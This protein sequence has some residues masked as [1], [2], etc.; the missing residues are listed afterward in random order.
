MMQA[1]TSSGSTSLRKTLLK[2][3]SARR[4]D[5]L[6]L[7]LLT[8]AT[9]PDTASEESE[10]SGS[11]YTDGSESEYSDSERGGVF[12][13]GTSSSTGKGDEDEATV[14]PVTAEKNAPERVGSSTPPTRRLPV[15]IAS[16]DTIEVRPQLLTAEQET[17]IEWV[18]QLLV[19]YVQRI[20][21]TRI[22]TDPEDA[23]DTKAPPDESQF[24]F[25]R[26]GARRCTSNVSAVQQSS[27]LDQV[28]DVIVFPKPSGEEAV[29]MEQD[30]HKYV[31]LTKE[32]TEQLRDFVE[33]ISG[34]YRGDN[35]FHN[36]SPERRC[37]VI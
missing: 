13:E 8:K 9:D 18:V 6:S 1:G 2:A 20:V 36:V 27:I 37:V 29:L 10:S 14:Q 23:S 35:P 25:S 19:P 33:E 28:A 32:V 4:S 16:T 17:L 5:D 31:E 24:I 26:P 15:R 3:G 11:E 30:A 21:A 7:S 12:I 34:L 22:M